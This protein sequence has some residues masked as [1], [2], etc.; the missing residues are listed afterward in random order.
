MTG[1]DILPFDRGEAVDGTA[2][3]ARLLNWP[4]VYVMDGSEQVYV[5]ETLSLVS[6]MRQHGGDRRKDPLR[7]V[8][9]VVHDEFNKSACLDL[10]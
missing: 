6:R 1:F 5:G 3:D 10:E 7:S 8:R 2:L 9:V 4:V